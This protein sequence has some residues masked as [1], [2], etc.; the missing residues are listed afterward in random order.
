[1]E[2][3]LAGGSHH[4]MEQPLAGGSHGRAAY[5]GPQVRG[6]GG[7]RHPAGGSHHCMEQTLPGGSYGSTAYP[8]PQ[9]RGIRGT[10]LCRRCARSISSDIRPVSSPTPP[11]GVI[12]GKYFI[13][14]DLA[15]EIY[16]KYLVLRYLKYKYL[17]TRYLCGL[18][19]DARAGRDN[20]G[21]RSAHD[22]Q[23]QVSGFEPNDTQMSFRRKTLITS[24][25]LRSG[26]RRG[27][28]TGWGAPVG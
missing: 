28:T 14:N 27:L 19:R 18:M 4:C 9:A 1:M 23:L 2:Q 26:R 22:S 25:I 21:L 12:L 5:P 24:W 16:C 10:R 7:T 3:T 11:G 17:K 8:G 13:F 6:T 20:A 15:A